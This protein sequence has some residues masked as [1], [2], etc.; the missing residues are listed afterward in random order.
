MQNSF[1]KIVPSAFV[2]LFLAIVGN[3]PALVLWNS[4]GNTTSSG[5]GSGWN[6]TG[7]VNNGS[8]VF[9]GNYSTGYWV[10]TASHVGASDF[11][12]NGTT[13]SYI[14]GSS[15]RITNPD[16]TDTD[17]VVF[18]VSSGPSLPNL[19]FGSISTGASVTMIGS[20]FDGASSKTYWDSSWSE[21]P[22]AGGASYV[23]YKWLDTYTKRWG[24]N[25]VSVSS[26]TANYGY[27]NVTMLGT[28]FDQSNGDAQVSTGDS[29]GG[30]FTNT[31]LLAGIMLTTGTYGSQPSSTS[32]A[33]DKSY[34]AD[35]SVYGSRILAVVPEPSILGLMTVAVVFLGVS[36]WSRSRVSSRRA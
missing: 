9:L 19:S 31:G 34:F 29:G 5:A 17:L 4:T 11:T 3:V 22:N 21:V 14:A 26:F 20:G 35:M 36:R 18:R 24:T 13:Y 28:T 10:L 27:G 12:L 16:G 6:Y 33:G 2:F 7:K 30:V 15:V 1:R 32:V 25:S 8:A 23:G